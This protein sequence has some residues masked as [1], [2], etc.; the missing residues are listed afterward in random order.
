M[1]FRS[2]IDTVTAEEGE[3]LNI[4]YR[5]S[6]LNQN[7]FN[8]NL[9]IDS[10]LFKTLKVYPG[11]NYWNISTLTEG[12]HKLEI[13]I[14]TIDGVY[15]EKLTITAVITAS[16]YEAIKPITQGLLAWFDATDK[17]NSDTNKDIWED[18]SGNGTVAR[19]YGF[20][21]NTNGWIDNKL[22]CNGNSYVEIDLTPFADNAISS[23]TI[24]IQFTARDIG[25]SEARVL[26]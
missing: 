24:D 22:L 18:K 11:I 4:D 9:Y 10:N 16:S 2:S 21:F 3:Q 15:T 5:I 1:L 13:E 12:E 17:N 20:N 23:L 19:L 14:S 26:D 8:V 25:N 6:M 7:Q